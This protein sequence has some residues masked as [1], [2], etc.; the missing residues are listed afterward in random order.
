MIPREIRS[1]LGIEPGSQICV[2]VEDDCII[3]EVVS[4]DLAD[5][6]RAYSMRDLG[7]PHR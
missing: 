3:V 7:F 2:R 1:S 6:T 5:K 4:E